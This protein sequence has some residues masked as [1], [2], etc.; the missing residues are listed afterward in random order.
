[1]RCPLLKCT[2]ISGRTAALILRGSGAT[3]WFA[4]TLLVSR[5]TKYLKYEAENP[6]TR[7]KSIFQCQEKA[8]ICG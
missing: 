7:R 2:Y 8:Y 4:N 3:H 6:S 5:I 1:M